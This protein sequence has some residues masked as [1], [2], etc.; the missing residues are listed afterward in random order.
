MARKG[1]GTQ[2]AGYRHPGTETVPRGI[3]ARSETTAFPGGRPRDFLPRETAVAGT[4]T[5]PGDVSHPLCDSN[6]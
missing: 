2:A 5:W 3:I 6:T 4:A 1:P